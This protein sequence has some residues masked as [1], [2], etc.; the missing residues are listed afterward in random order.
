MTRHRRS[1]RPLLLGQ[2]GNAPPCTY[3]VHTAHPSSPSTLVRGAQFLTIGD[4]VT[5]GFPA[6][7]HISRFTLNEVKNEQTFVKSD[8]TAEIMELGYDVSFD[9]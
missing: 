8:V 2:A 6:Q 5:I 7:V 3:P 1:V 9:K 4:E